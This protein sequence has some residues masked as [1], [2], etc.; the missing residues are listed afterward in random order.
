MTDQNQT[1]FVFSVLLDNV[2]VKGV[3]ASSRGS[4][5]LS[6]VKPRRTAAEA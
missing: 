3:P 2:I 5:K 1:C 4:T 6:L